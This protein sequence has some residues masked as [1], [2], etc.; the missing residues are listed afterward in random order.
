MKNFLFLFALLLSFCFQ[1][2][3]AQSCLPDGITFSRQSQVDSFPILFPGCI[4]IEG[5]V[6]IS[7]EDIINLSGLSEVIAMESNL[8]IN[9]NT[10]LT[11]LAGLENLSSVGDGLVILDNDR[12]ASLS[13]FDNLRS[14]G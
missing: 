3:A 5:E 7:G 2:T 12:L 13:G 9:G 14:V 6:V 8:L 1:N 11:S 4:T 10:S